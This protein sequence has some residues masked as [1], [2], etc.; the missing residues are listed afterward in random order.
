MAKMKTIRETLEQLLGQHKT[1]LCYGQADSWTDSQSG[2]RELRKL[3]AEAPEKYEMSHRKSKRG[4]KYLVYAIKGC[5]KARK[6][7]NGMWDV[8]DGRGWQITTEG[9]KTRKEA[10]AQIKE[11]KR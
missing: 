10:K 7:A 11:V 3:L 8:F 2:G 5:M 9:F 1:A 6:G 4:S